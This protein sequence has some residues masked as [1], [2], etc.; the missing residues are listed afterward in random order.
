M[1]GVEKKK[2]TSEDEGTMDLGCVE[3]SRGL[4][5]FFL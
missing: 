3:I 5:S 4:S 1:F 2:E